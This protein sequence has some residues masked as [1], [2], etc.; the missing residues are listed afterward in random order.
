MV[1]K[2]GGDGVVIDSISGAT[3]TS[4]AVTKGVNGACE[5]VDLL[6]EGG[7]SNEEE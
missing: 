4:R 3:I 6:L 7:V 5:I 2:D 1:D